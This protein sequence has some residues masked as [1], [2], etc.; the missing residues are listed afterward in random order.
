[1]SEI[2]S[3]NKLDKMLNQEMTRRKFMR[4]SGKSLAG[5]T[6]SASLLSLFG[7]TQEQVDSDSVSLWTTPTGLLVVNQAKCTGCQR[8]EINC[9][10]VNDGCVSSHISRVKVTR[11]LMS[12][13]GHGTYEN[14]WVYYP[15]TCRQCDKP[16]CGEVCPKE[17]IYADENGVK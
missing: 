9:T 17:A 1:M 4:I 12:N 15:D 6:V 5:L 3:Q 16:F 13:N 2:K 7:C 11:N 14:D 8:C 10:V